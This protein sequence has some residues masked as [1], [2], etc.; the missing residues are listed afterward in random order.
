MRSILPTT[1]LTIALLALCSSSFA[2]DTSSLVIRIANFPNKLFG[3][4]NNK[5]SD[6]NKQLDKQTEKYLNKLAGQEAKLK[7]KLYKY[8]SAAAKNL[9]PS[10]YEQQYAL[11]LQKLKND[12]TSKPRPPSGEYYP[13]VDSMQTSLSFLKQNPNLLDVS[14]VMPGDIEASMNKLHTLQA[15]MQDADQIKHYIQ[16]RKEQLRQYLSRYTAPPPSIMNAYQGYN[17]QL[18]YYGEQIKQYKETLNDPDKM[19][20]LALTVLNKIPAFTSFVKSNSVLSGI[21]NLSGNYNPTATGLGLTTRDQVVAAF[22]NQIGAITAGGP[23]NPSSVMQQGMQSAQ[24]SVD[25]LR[26]KLNSYGN[27]G[28]ADVDIPNFHPNDQKSKSFLKRIQIGTNMQTVHSTYFFPATTDFGLS[29]GYKLNSKNAVGVGASYKMGWGKDISHINLSGQGAGLRSYLDINLKK[30][31]YVSGGLEY[32]YQQPI[33]I[34]DFPMLK[35]WQQS[36]LLGLSKIVS[37]KTKFFKSTKIQVLWDFL[38]YEQIP[39]AQPIKFR[40]GYNF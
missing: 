6:L 31:F 8:D 20:K 13:Y 15:K 30:S 12:T 17:K 7:K 9:Y 38:S 1:A 25:Q 3:K 34:A 23:N 33:N 37:L 28:S 40:V 16:Q 18:Y 32:N 27:S 11:W 5:V 22:Q 39:K 26:D 14:K 10:N 19:M 24:G 36:G 2:Q 29:I 21:F 4:I 35:S